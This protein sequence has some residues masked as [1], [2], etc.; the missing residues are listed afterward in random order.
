MHAHSHSTHA[1]TDIEYSDMSVHMHTHTHVHVNMHV[2][3]CTLTYAHAFIHFPQI[4]IYNLSTYEY[5]AVVCMCGYIISAV[6]FEDAV[7]LGTA[8]ET[9]SYSFATL[10]R[11]LP[12]D[13]P[14]LMLDRT[15]SYI[16][17]SNA[18]LVFP[19]SVCL[20]ILH[21]S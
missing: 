14:Y 19:P 16:C 12:S 17:S 11:N 13:L 21:F 3:A 10:N 6:L 7:I 5:V 15:V 4:T 20:Y 1:H 9:I 18:S 8:S 2:H